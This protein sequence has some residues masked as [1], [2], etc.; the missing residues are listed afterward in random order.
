MHFDSIAARPW[1]LPPVGG[2]LLGGAAVD[3]Q[4][5]VNRRRSEALAATPPKSHTAVTAVAVPSLLSTVGVIG[6]I[7][8]MA[9]PGLR[10]R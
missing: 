6:V 5:R 3:G 1:C 2:Q 9:P 7:G 4:G 10:R 8:A